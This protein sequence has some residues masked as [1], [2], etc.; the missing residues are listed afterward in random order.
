MQIKVGGVI[1]L[2]FGLDI[3]TGE[4][5]LEETTEAL[6][7]LQI[8]L[9]EK[10]EEYLQRQKIKQRVSIL[11]GEIQGMINMYNI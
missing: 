4:K 6:N 3:V 1:S 11:K 10:R 5:K 7:G 9:G 2:A 8:S